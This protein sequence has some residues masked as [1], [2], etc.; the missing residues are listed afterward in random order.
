MNK[1]EETN[2]L[3]PT[4]KTALQLIEGGKGGPGY[5]WLGDMEVGTVFAAADKMNRES[6][7]IATQFEVVSKH[8]RTVVLVSSLNEPQQYI[9]V[10]PLQ[11]SIRFDLIETIFDPKSISDVNSG[12]E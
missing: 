7:F 11:F 6:S 8:Q 3:I 2:T 4:Q 5:N 12:N 1:T 10:R 9:S